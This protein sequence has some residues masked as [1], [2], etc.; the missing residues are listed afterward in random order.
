MLLDAGAD[1]NVHGGESDATPAMWAAQ[2]GFY[3][4]VHLLLTHGTDVTMVDSAGYNLLHLATFDGNVFLLV[5]LL[6]HGIPVDSRDREGH[7]SLMWAAY[8]GFAECVDLFLRWGADTHAVD[9]HGFTALH[10]ALVRGNYGC[11]EKLLEYGVDRFVM[12]G[13]GKTPAVVASEVKT[14]KAWWDALE[15]CGFDRNGHP[16]HP[17]NTLFGIHVQDKDAALKRFF[18]LW[19]FAQVFLV[20]QCFVYMP[21][22]LAIPS[23]VGVAVGMHWVAARALQWAPPGR[24]GIHKTPYLSGVFAGSAGWVGVRWAWAI[25]PSAPPLPPPV[26]I[27]YLTS[28]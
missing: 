18:Y 22:F 12:N 15:E 8:K 2:R 13:D 3:Y 14:E 28:K 27:H 23:A 7:S 5:V 17:P 16:M 24:K 26:P 1:P 10:W 11:I 25:L 9:E 20:V 4:I 19:P 21:W 6:H